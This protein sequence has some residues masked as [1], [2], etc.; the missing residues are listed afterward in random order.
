MKTKWFKVFIGLLIFCMACSTE[1]AK[2][3]LIANAEMQFEV[4]GMVCEMGCA[5]TIEEKVSGMAGV[6][7]CKVDFANKTAQISFDHSAIKEGEI[8]KAIE[9]MHDGQYQLKGIEVKQKTGGE[10]E[11]EK[12]EQLK[13]ADDP[14]SVNEASFSFPELITYFMRNLK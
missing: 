1:V 13:G 5:K 11:V 8:Q 4:E 7:S 14:V 10:E 9:E 6:V 2:K 3:D 12:A